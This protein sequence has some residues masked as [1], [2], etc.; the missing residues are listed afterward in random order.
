[1]LPAAHLT[2]Q[3]SSPDD[4]RQRQLVVSLDGAPFA[5]LLFGGRVTRDVSPGRHRLRIHNTLVWRTIE[6]EVRAGEHLRFEAVNRA[7][8]G[9]M[10]L[11]GLLGV[12][13]LYV[14]VRRLDD[15]ES[16]AS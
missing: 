2:V 5:T 9:T 1:M 6:V 16:G 7:G 15:P 12:G 8:P 10:A 4:V 13:P 14:T 11:I 3:R